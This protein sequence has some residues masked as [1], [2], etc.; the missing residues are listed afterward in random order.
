MNWEAARPVYLEDL[1]SGQAFAL[2][3]AWVNPE[4]LFRFSKRFDPQPMHL[5]GERPIASGW[6]TASLAMEMIV[7][8]A[9]FG[10][11]AILGMGV[12]ELRWP[13][14]VLP[15]DVLAGTLTV[16][17]TRPFSSRPDRGFVRLSV[18]VAN[19]A[20]TVVFTMAPLTVVPRR[21]A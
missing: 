17:E 21:N 15:G 5:D 7:R 12:D 10:S 4:E 18:V 6:F 8:A 9:P 16:L 13:A 2:G 11:T 19:Q 14:P 20:S 1:E 3:P